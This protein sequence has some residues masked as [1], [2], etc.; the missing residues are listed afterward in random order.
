[1]I[2]KDRKDY[3]PQHE[4]IVYGWYGQHK[5]ESR[6]G[7]TVIFNPRPQKSVLHPTMKPIPL[8]RKFILNST[9]IGDTVYDPFGGSGSTMIGCEH[10]KRRCLMIEKDE[11]YCQVIIDR[12]N[13]LLTN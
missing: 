9:K 11:T 6:Q 2:I 3:N 4:L 5:F 8:L 1:M 7:K 12:F 10:T 13:K